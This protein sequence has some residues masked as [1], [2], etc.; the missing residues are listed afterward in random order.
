MADKKI[1][2]L[3]AAATPL[4]GTEVLPI[5]QS[6]S[7]VKVSVDNLTAG[8]AV[9]G[10]SFVPTGSTV[11][12]NG[13]FL[14]A[15][16]SVSIATNSVKNLTVRPGGIMSVGTTPASWYIPGDVT[17]VQQVGA[18]TVTLSLYGNQSHF[19]SNFYMKTGTGNDT[20]IN[21]GVAMRYRQDAGMHVFE[22]APSG[23][24]DTTVTFTPLAT[25]A[26][27][28]NFT[29]HTN[30]I[31]VGA[32]GK[33][34]TTGSAIPLGLGVNNT[35]T[36]AKIDTSGNFLIAKADADFGAVGFEYLSSAKILRN[37]ADD[38]AAAQFNRLTSD[39]DIIGFY[40]SGASVGSISVTTTG[41]AYNIT[42]DARLKHDIVDALDAAD[43]IDAL[44]VR[45][46]KWN[47][48]GSEQRYGFVAQELF[49]VAP[50]AV[51]VPE[52]ED[53]MMGVDYSKLVPMLVKEI[54]S[55]R[56]R[57]AQ[58]EGK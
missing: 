45:S 9:S 36:A 41:T 29:V 2:A 50:E 57:V 44:Q 19:G 52:D 11:P 55:L 47:V 27:N 10:A 30:N 54:Q 48:D 40:R 5:V 26:A 33:G 42:S 35:V 6:G 24:A 7:T 23:T 18:N 58:L 3:T 56:A 38:G 15:A 4:A 16:N 49:E 32:A 12:T 25:V 39:G 53:K 17:S 21:T 1:S 14:D 37:T 43:L 22:S 31:I 51:T 28:G 20:Y 34:I 13:L 46:F 8:K